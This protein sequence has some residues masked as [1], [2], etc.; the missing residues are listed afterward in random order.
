MLLRLINLLNFTLNHLLPKAYH[1]SKIHPHL[2]E[3]FDSKLI[4]L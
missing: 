2:T 1:L 4:N 3:Q